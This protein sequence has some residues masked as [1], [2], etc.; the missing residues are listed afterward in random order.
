MDLY[1]FF[2]FENQ[3][4]CFGVEYNFKTSWCVYEQRSIDIQK[5]RVFRGR[6]STQENTLLNSISFYKQIMWR[7]K[8]NIALSIY[9][10]IYLYRYFLFFILDSLVIQITK[11]CM[12]QLFSTN[13]FSHDV[14]STF[15]A[16]YSQSIV[17]TNNFF[18]YFYQRKQKSRK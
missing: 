8:G 18:T 12:A 5:K 7:H 3:M 14:L 2:L 10:Y 17:N 4:L 15:T 11:N 6:E 16:I 13:A 1:D 9:I